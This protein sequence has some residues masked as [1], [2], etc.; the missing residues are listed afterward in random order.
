M[1]TKHLQPPGQPRLIGADASHAW[2][3]VWTPDWGWLALAPTNGTRPVN[4]TRCW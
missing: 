1:L 2:L 4:S 3:A